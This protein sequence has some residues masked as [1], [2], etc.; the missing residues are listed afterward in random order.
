LELDNTHFRY[1]SSPLSWE[2][3]TLRSS[4]TDSIIVSLYLIVLILTVIFYMD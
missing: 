1:Y 2:T 4:D 3:L